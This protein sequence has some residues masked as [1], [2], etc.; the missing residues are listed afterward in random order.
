MHDWVKVL[1]TKPP[2]KQPPK[3]LT[4]IKC[5]PPS[6]P[7]SSIHFVVKAVQEVPEKLLGILL[8]VIIKQEK[9]YVIMSWLRITIEND[10]II[11]RTLS[12]GLFVV[13][14]KQ[15]E[16][17]TYSYPLNLGWHLINWLRNRKGFEYELLEDFMSSNSLPNAIMR[18]VLWFRM[19]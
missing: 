18:G 8:S 13:I 15:R 4:G 16:I 6:C 11:E 3:K 2:L 1:P 14:T 19:T 10:I 17:M 5:L 12:T 7:S 9:Y